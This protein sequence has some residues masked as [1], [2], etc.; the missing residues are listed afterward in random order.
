MES[1]R[2]REIKP[3]KQQKV[4][5]LQLSLILPNLPP[6]RFNFNSFERQWTSTAVCSFFVCLRTRNRSIQI[7]AQRIFFVQSDARCRVFR[8]LLF[9]IRCYNCSVV[10]CVLL[11]ICEAT[12]GN[13]ICEGNFVVFSVS[14]RWEIVRKVEE[15]KKRY[16]L[17]YDDLFCY[18]VE[19]VNNWQNE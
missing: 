6:S 1:D 13:C 19:A 11:W 16:A 5:R 14:R 2:K 10:D 17:H 7:Y 8:F 18:S 4:L 9:F 15:R 12:A 3:M